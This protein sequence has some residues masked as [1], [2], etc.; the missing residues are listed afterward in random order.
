MT[1]ILIRKQKDR[2]RGRIALVHTQPTEKGHSQW[3]LCVCVCVC[4]SILINIIKITSPRHAQSPTLSSWSHKREGRED[5]NGTSVSP[6]TLVLLKGLGGRR[7]CRNHGFCTSSIILHV[8]HH[9]QGLLWL[10]SFLALKGPEWWH[11]GTTIEFPHLETSFQAKQVCYLWK[12]RNNF[13]PIGRK[14]CLEIRPV[15]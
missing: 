14:S 10:N 7:T 2:D 5:R 6:R 15:D 11:R 4:L 9:H 8:C 1:I 12:K 13:T 3:G